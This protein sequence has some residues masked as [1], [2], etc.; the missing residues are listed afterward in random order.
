[1]PSYD[2][3]LD[4]LRTWLD[5]WSGIGHVTVGMHRSGLW[6]AERRF[7][8]QCDRLSGPRRPT[9]S[10]LLPDESSSEAW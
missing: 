3:V 6:S 10:T 2:R 4:A 9:R 8:G 5:S 1:M 7:M